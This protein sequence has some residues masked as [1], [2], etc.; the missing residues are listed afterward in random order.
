MQSKQLVEEYMLL[1]NVLV[2]EFLYQKIGDKT[3]LRVHDE[4]NDNKKVALASFFGT[5]GLDTIDLNDSQSLNR[6]VQAT[7]DMVPNKE[8]RETMEQVINRKIF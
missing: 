1:A 7:L 5:L 4:I 8:E 2:A 6:S 3:L